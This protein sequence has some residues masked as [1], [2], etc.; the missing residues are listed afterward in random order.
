MFTSVWIKCDSLKK[1]IRLFICSL[2]SFHWENIAM[3]FFVE[4]LMLALLALLFTIIFSVLFPFVL[5]H[6]IC[7]HVC[8]THF[9]LL[10]CRFAVLR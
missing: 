6:S 3:A 4:L 10:L 9:E 7:F 8:V 5:C 1:I 2:C